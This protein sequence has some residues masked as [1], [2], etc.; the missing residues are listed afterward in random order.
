LALRRK[1]SNRGP[2]MLR[3]MLSCAAAS[4][5]K[6]SPCARSSFAW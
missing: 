6:G 3:Q 4:P 5:R 2:Q 1:R